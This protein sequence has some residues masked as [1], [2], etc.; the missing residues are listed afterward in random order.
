MRGVTP[1][2]VELELLRWEPG[3]V[4]V[5]GRLTEEG[6]ALGVMG[7]RRSRSSRTTRR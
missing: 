4:V 5:D 2:V 6:F 3:G 7:M 1:A